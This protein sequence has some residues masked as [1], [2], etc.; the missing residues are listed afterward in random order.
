MTRGACACNDD[1]I[2]FENPLNWTTWSFIFAKQGEHGNSF[3]QVVA[4]ASP[5]Q[6]KMCSR[7]VIIIEI[8][9]EGSSQRVFM[10]H[11]Q[12]IEAPASNGADH[13]FYIGT[14]PR[15]ARCRQN[16]ADPKSRD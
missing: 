8:R 16:F 7:S 14:L 9:I 12:M 15:R 4:P 6:R 1:K 5:P 10:E 3:V 2:V 13:A 11:D